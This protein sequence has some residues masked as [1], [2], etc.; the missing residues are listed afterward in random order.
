[1]DQINLSQSL[2]DQLLSVL[3]EHDSQCQDEL[4]A[5]QY[6]EAVIG[7]ADSRDRKSFLAELSAFIQYVAQDLEHKGAQPG[8]DAADSAFG[9]WT[10]EGG[11]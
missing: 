1:M 6:M 2:V 5:S 8:A 9:I 7:L 11:E 3:R 10:P 4:I